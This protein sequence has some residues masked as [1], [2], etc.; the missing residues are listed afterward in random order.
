[1]EMLELNPDFWRDRHVFVT[2]HTGF[3]GGWLCLW[4]QSLGAKVH[5]YSLNPP[6]EPN[7]FCVA[8][9]GEGMAENTIAD[10]RDRPAFT[11]AMQ[12]AQAEVVFHLA[13]QSLVRHSYANPVETYE[14]N[15]MGTVNMLEAVRATPSVRCVVNVTS[16]KCYENRESTHAHSEGDALGGHDPYSNSKACSELVTT[17]YRSSFLDAAGVALA[18]ARAG[19]VIGGGD[20]AVDR[21]VPDILRAMDAGVAPHIRSPD[22]IRPW[23]HA[24]EPLSGY[25][26]LAEKLF[27]EQSAFA[28]AWNFGPCGEVDRSVRW[29][30]DRLTSATPGEGWAMDSANQPHEAAHLALDSNKARARLNWRPRWDLSTALEKTLEWHSAWRNGNDMRAVTLAQITEYA[31]HV[32][33]Q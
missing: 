23:Q 8:R 21:L 7:L 28:E 17:A 16:D 25:L 33:A 30:V 11:G 3:K 2:G 18:S 24:L 10:V 4:L 19:N 14:V 26:L 9:I 1:M 22:A 27:V 31:N 32:T 15:V 29:I 6:T 13:A 5:G 12:D 20:W